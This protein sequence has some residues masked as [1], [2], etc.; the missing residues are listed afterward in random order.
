MPII[1][2]MRK[3]EKSKREKIGC[4]KTKS[5]K[6]KVFLMPIKYL[7]KYTTTTKMLQQTKSC[8]ENKTC[9]LVVFI[10]KISQ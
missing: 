8:L 6:K 5:I 1:N 2:K 7:L 9:K 4:A 3:R 10:K